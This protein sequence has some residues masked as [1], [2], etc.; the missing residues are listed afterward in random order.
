MTIKIDAGY[1]KE[2]LRAFVEEGLPD[3]GVENPD[4]FIL[5]AGKGND[6]TFH[7]SSNSRKKTLAA[8]LRAVYLEE[9]NTAKLE[10]ADNGE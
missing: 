7:T 9:G 4:I 3:A 6:L 5:V 2:S 8:L 10:G 1:M